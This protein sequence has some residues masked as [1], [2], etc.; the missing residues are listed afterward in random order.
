MKKTRSLLQVFYR[1]L[2]RRVVSVEGLEID[3]I[4]SEVCDKTEVP[5]VGPKGLLASPSAVYSIGVEPHD[6][7]SCRGSLNC[8]LP[9]RTALDSE[10]LLIIAEHAYHEP[11]SPNS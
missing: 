4:C 5:P 9:W 3:S 7:L 10:R 1:K 8:Q 11:L 6:E 2:D